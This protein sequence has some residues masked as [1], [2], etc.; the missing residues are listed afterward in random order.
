[1]AT[2]KQGPLLICHDCQDEIRCVI[3]RDI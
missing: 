3:D 1:M 2:W